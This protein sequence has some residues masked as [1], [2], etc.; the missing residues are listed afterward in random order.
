MRPPL[1]PLDPVIDDAFE[2]TDECSPFFSPSPG[3]NSDPLPLLIYLRLDRVSPL[4]VESEGVSLSTS[5]P[6]LSK[7]ISTSL[8]PPR[9]IPHSRLRHFFS[10]LPSANVASSTRLVLAVPGRVP[11]REPFSPCTSLLP[12]RSSGFSL[13]L[14]PLDA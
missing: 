1:S 3:L 6:P 9:P 10:S 2:I 11:L 5:S 8:A 13:Q 12:S 7:F 14:F 4:R